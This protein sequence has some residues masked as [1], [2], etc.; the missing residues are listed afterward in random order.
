[1]AKVWISQNHI[2]RMIAEI[3]VF[4]PLETGGAF[5]GYISLENNVVITDLIDAGVGAKRG[6][7][8]FEPEQDYQLAEMERLYRLSN[9]K[10]TYLGDWHSH[11]AN[12]PALSRRDERTLLKIASS[13]QA[14]CPAPVM[15]IIGSHPEKWLVNCVR[16]VKGRKRIWPFY[17]CEYESLEVMV[18]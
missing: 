16:F 2:D 4:A 10:T 9:G 5:F 14:K 3:E 1:M 17:S 13:E 11:P 15:M 7:Y 18:D 8:S 12:A 6:R